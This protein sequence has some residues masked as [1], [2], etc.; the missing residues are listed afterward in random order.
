MHFLNTEM[1]MGLKTTTSPTGQLEAITEDEIEL[2][3][4]RFRALDSDS[5]GFITVSDL[6]SYF[7]VTASS[8]KY[9]NS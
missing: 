5:K 3:I 1:G 7:K 2:Y 8:A 6:R 4:K 9:E